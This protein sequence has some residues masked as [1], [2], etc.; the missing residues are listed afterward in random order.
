VNGR[1]FHEKEHFDKGVWHRTRAIR[2][3]R[4]THDAPPPT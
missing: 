3:S 1:G 2:D 4:S